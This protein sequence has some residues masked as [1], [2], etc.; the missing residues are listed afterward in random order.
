MAPEEDENH[1]SQKVIKVA[2]DD[3][4]FERMVNEHNNGVIN[5]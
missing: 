2:D 1:P 5:R 4:D 3:M